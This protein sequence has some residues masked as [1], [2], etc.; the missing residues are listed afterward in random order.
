MERMSPIR[1]QITT[2]AAEWF[3]RLGEKD[4]SAATREAFVQ[5][6]LRSPQHIEEY[7]AITRAWGDAAYARGDALSKENLIRAAREEPPTSNVIPLSLNPPNVSHPASA[8]TH[9]GAERAQPH[10]RGLWRTAAAAMVLIAVALVWIG[11]EHVLGPRTIHTAIGEQR[12]ITLEDGSVVSLNTASKLSYA[13]D[14]EERRITLEKGEARFDVAKDAARPFVV[15]TSQATVRALGTVFNVQVAPSSTAVAVLEGRVEVVS[16]EAESV[17]EERSAPDTIAAT[18]RAQQEEERVQRPTRIQL[19]AGEQAAVTPKG[20]I[21]ANA[22]PP[23]ERVRAW[24]ERRLIFREERLSDVIAE[25][26]RYHKQALR[27]DDPALAEHRI[28]G[29]FAVQD[30]ASLLQYL[31]RYQHVEIEKTRDARVLRR[32][33]EAGD[34]AI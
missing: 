32:R 24:T 11:A 21:L 6:M 3:T 4:V 15:S 26:N 12:T 14:S 2:E 20:E 29:T 30:V 22:G 33:T 31:E 7:L 23:L 19:A 17:S 28:S 18:D 27:I 5:W 13:F 25:F 8:R 16:R 34:P 10:S 9:D 1:E